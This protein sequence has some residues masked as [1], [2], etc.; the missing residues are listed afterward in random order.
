MLPLASF[1]TRCAARSSPMVL[2]VSGPPEVP[3]FL[4]EL[5]AATHAN[6]VRT[7]VRRRLPLH[8]GNEET[9]RDAS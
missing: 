3:E 2:T 6:S 5:F 1:R 7:Q 4:D 9:S 8:R